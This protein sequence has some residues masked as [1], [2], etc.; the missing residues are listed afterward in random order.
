MSHMNKQKQQQ[1]QQQSTTS[2]STSQ[3]G[4]IQQQPLYSSTSTSATV[5]GSTLASSTFGSGSGTSATSAAAYTTL[6]QLQ[7]HHQQQY[8][9]LPQQQQQQPYSSLRGVFASSSGGSSRMYGNVGDQSYNQQSSALD[10]QSSS[11]ASQ[12]QL[13]QQQQQQQQPRSTPLDQARRD[14]LLLYSSSSSV[15]ANQPITSS[16]T[17]MLST[18]PASSSTAGQSSLGLLSSMNIY[19]PYSIE[20]SSSAAGAAS[21]SQ[22]GGAT[23]SSAS[24]A[25]AAAAGLYRSDMGFQSQFGYS[26]NAVATE[27]GVA[28]LPPHQQQQQQQ[29]QQASAISYGMNPARSSFSLGGSGLQSSAHD[30]QQY[31][32]TSG[33]VSGLDNSGYSGVLPLTDFHG[34]HQLSGQNSAKSYSAAGNHPSS[35]I[36]QPLGAFVTQQHQ[37]G[38]TPTT[39][40]SKSDSGSGTRAKESPHM[41]SPNR[42]TGGGGASGSASAASS[43][44]QQQQQQQHSPANVFKRF[45]NAFIFYVNEQRRIRSDDALTKNRDFLKMMS[46]EWKVMTELEK[47]PYYQMAQED[48]ERYENDQS[49]HGR[50][51]PKPRGTHVKPHASTSSL[52][53][54]T[55]ATTVQ[56][57]QKPRQLGS[58][59][60]KHSSS[61]ASAATSANIIQPFASPQAYSTLSSPLSGI[62]GQNTGMSAAAAHALGRIDH[63]QSGG[64]TPAYGLTGSLLGAGSTTDPFSLQS[65]NQQQQYQQ[66]SHD[67]HQ[68]SQV[69][70]LLGSNYSSML[71]LQSMDPTAAAAVNRKRAFTTS[72]AA[73]GGGGG[74]TGATAYGSY[75]TGDTGSIGDMQQHQASQSGSGSSAHLDMMNP[76]AA[77][78][79]AVAASGLYAP[80]TTGY[81]QLLSGTMAS[82]TGSVGVLSPDLT[83]TSQ[84]VGDMKLGFASPLVPI[85]QQQQQQQQQQQLSQVQSGQYQL[86]SDINQQIPTYGSWPSVVATPPGGMAVRTTGDADIQPILPKLDPIDASTF[87]S[88]S[89][90]EPQSPHSAAKALAASRNPR[91]PGSTLGITGFHPYHRP[92]HSSLSQLRGQFDQQQQQ[93]QQQQS[94]YGSI[95]ADQSQYHT[96]GGHQ[97]QLQS[98]GGTG[99]DEQ[100]DPEYEE[101][102][103]EANDPSYNDSKRRHQHH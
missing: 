68:H 96:Q 6:P 57:S 30:L 4:H 13:Q 41:T 37:S 101:D 92:S 56:Q 99:D 20:Q 77:A 50:F 54:S 1:Q 17:N 78:A 81:S 102:D 74:G 98:Y 62:V 80:V 60:R 39:V 63:F 12:L 48:R 73:A 61:S 89:N 93:Q 100:D 19:N 79:A 23:S 24:T 35:S 46:A 5:Q 95:P 43:Q 49:R 33:S 22:S 27:T 88:L 65:H 85:T 10:N 18:Q 87:G 2:V 16:A 7:Y 103:D 97:S 64:I 58:G 72:S 52:D 69:A 59:N 8:Y 32:G 44:Q 45:R 26:S 9:Q 55:A 36:V 94:L 42:S 47:Q 84:M 51:V 90:T 21:T 67:Q 76:A 31:G 75:L 28:F 82:S 14:S 34:L 86:T 91:S 3:S 15:T 70:P 71:S 40:A 11:S 25:T 66:Q 83:L 29:Q 53:D 38:S